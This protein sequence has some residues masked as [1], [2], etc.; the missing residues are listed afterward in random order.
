MN[1][2]LITA[3]LFSAFHFGMADAYAAEKIRAFAPDSFGRIVAS[4]S[5]KPFV[6]MVWELDCAYCQ[7]SFHAL[8]QAQ[9]KYKFSVITIATDRVDDAQ[10]SRLIRKKLDASGLGS[11]MWAFGAAPAEQLR[12]A[13]DPKWR[14]EMP[15]SYWFNA[16][17]KSVAYSGVITADTV[18]K[19]LPK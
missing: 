6:V 5:G 10:A 7:E 15:R 2:L 11:N 3:L 19:F 1:R 13:I 12:Y 9:H 14:G 8:A 17:G 16:D 18:S 4:H